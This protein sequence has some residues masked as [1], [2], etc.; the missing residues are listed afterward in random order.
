MLKSA[1]LSFPDSD[2]LNLQRD[3]SI[4]RSHGLRFPLVLFRKSLKLS[5]GKRPLEAF[6]AGSFLETGGKCGAGG[7]VNSAVNQIC[8][9][10]DP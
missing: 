2:H 4:R 6:A 9:L 7:L 8:L 1:F 10:L 3:S 5:M